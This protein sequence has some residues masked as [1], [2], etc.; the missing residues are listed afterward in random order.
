MVAWAVLTGGCGSTEAPRFWG[1]PPFGPEIQSVIYAARGE[2]RAIGHGEATTLVAAART[3]PGASL[4]LEF[5]T[6]PVLELVALAYPVDLVALD[7]AGGVIERPQGDEPTRPL[8]APTEAWARREP[9]DPSW[10]AIEPDPELLGRTL[11]AFDPLRCVGIGRCPSGVPT[12][13]SPCVLP[14]APIPP[15]PPEPPLAPRHL[16]CG[17]SSSTTT[18]FGRDVRACEPRPS[19]IPCG[20]GQLQPP[21]LDRCVPAAPPQ[22][23]RWPATLPLGPTYYVDAAA[24]PGGDG[25]EGAPYRTI[26]EALAN[27]PPGAVVVLAA[28]VYAESV[29][30]AD[31]RS[32]IGVGAPEARIEGPAGPGVATVSTGTVR[33]VTIVGDPALVVGGGGALTVSE[34]ILTGPR[35]LLV[36]GTLTAT[37]LW[38]DRVTGRAAELNGRAELTRGTI[39]GLGSGVLV[40]GPGAALVADALL[41][42][43]LS[44]ALVVRDGAELSLSRV[45]LEDVSGPGIWVERA[46]ARI[47]DLVIRDRLDSPRTG[48]AVHAYQ[49]TVTGERWQLLRGPGEGLM[50]ELGG[51]VELSDVEV[52][53]QGIRA[54]QADT[55]GILSLRRG[56]GVRG[57]AGGMWLTGRAEA[58]LEDLEF[59]DCPQLDRGHAVMLESATAQLS[60][61]RITGGVGQGVTTAGISARLEVTDLELSHLGNTGLTLAGNDDVVI[62]ERLNIFDTAGAAVVG[63]GDT[64]LEAREVHASGARSTAGRRSATLSFNT[65]SE[66]QLDTFLVEDNLIAGLDLESSQQ[67]PTVKRLRA[68]LVRNNVVGLFYRA[69]LEEFSAILE[70]VVFQDNQLLLGTE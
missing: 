50:V 2:P 57:G 6:E 65:G 56:R 63:T 30:L 9:G 19:S 68:G 11:R 70:Q 12:T 13:C 20:P 23:G 53:D 21:D 52:R 14:R 58:V 42:Q 17:S 32:L 67:D 26:N 51:R 45:V 60:R 22:V 35:G 55:G 39:S 1:Q 38:I 34:V 31:G 16:G 28:G 18:W 54:F 47:D 5:P 40:A 10:Q 69:A 41:L 64:Y 7:L 36:N 49:G 8:P 3:G 4:L 37:D 15:A 27:S 61:G 66:V 44:G 62:A 24:T 43:S 46:N 48:R 25:S 59:I 29:A 33:G